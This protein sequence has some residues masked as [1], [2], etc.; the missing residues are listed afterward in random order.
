M[1][2]EEVKYVDDVKEL[3]KFP[4]TKPLLL[5]EKEYQCPIDES[6]Y[7]KDLSIWP[8]ADKEDE[9]FATDPEILLNIR[10]GNTYIK[11]DDKEYV[12][13]RKGLHKFFDLYY[14]FVSP[15]FRF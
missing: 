15:E 10:R 11:I 9:V 6:L 4:D 12:I 13:G 3:Y 7:I 5:K 8:R 14:K 2:L 1:L